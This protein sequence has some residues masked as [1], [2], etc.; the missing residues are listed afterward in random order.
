MRR[1]RGRTRRQTSTGQ[2]PRRRLRW[3][4]WFLATLITLPVA[5]GSGYAVAA[6]ILFPVGDQASDE[7]VAV[8]RLTGRDRAD[9]ER[10]LGALGLTIEG[11]SELPH[12]LE[13]AG[14]VIAQSP[15][16]GQRL[17][18]GAAVRLAISTGRP[19][20]RIPDL[21]G[22]PYRDAASLAESLGFTVN[23]REETGTG[24]AD[25]VLRVEPAPGTTRELPAT[26]VLIVTAPPQP[27]PMAPGDS[28]YPPALEWESGLF[29]A[30]TTPDQRS[31]GT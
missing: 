20:L 3:G 18:A 21:I 6:L 8:P 12:P 4:R 31:P 19:Q 10:E 22:L 2:T 17:H 16:A 28:L 14:T 25:L 1:S 15:L 9:A 24:A 27:E 23:R 11:A 13:P 29:P 5:F 7:L 26:I 30:D